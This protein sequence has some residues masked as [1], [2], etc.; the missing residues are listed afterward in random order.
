MEQT[1]SAA[2]TAAKDRAQE[3]KDILTAWS[4]DPAEFGRTPV[5]EAILEQ[6]RQNQA[7]RDI[8]RYLGRF[9]EIFAQ[10]RKNGYTYG[11][12]ETYSL[13]LGNDI[14]RAL[15]SE[16]SMLASPQTVPL[17]LRKYQ[18]KRIKQYRRREP[19]YKG[20]GDMLCC[21]DESGSMEGGPIA[22]GKAVAMTLLEIAAESK[23]KFALIHFSGSRS[24][25]IDLFLPGEYTW[26]G[27]LRACEGFLGGGTDYEAPLT[28]ALRLME[29]GGFE[30]ADIVFLTDGECSLPED[31][32]ETLREEQVRK[33]FTV[34][35]ILLDEGQDLTFSLS[36][37]CRHVYRM[38]Q[39]DG[40]EIFRSL[41]N[42][43]A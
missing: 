10:G 43:I 2:V 25:Q 11:R 41:V 38:S 1:V 9:R 4:D 27:K 42:D 16:L 8:S 22:W 17:F 31:F 30:N 14:G 13:E 3:A 6:V 26:K 40:E 5:N 37:F 28:E 32:S 12:G 39:L 21:L 35:G 15:T 24:V 7:L 18:Q 34:T 23:R 20:M 29:S 36:P 33:N 19:A